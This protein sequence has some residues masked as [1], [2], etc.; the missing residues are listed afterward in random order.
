MIFAID[1]TTNKKIIVA[2]EA[3]IEHNIQKSPNAFLKDFF[4]QLNFNITI[5]Q[6]NLVSGHLNGVLFV[7]CQCDSQ[8]VSIIIAGGKNKKQTSK[9]YEF[10]PTDNNKVNILTTLTTDI[11]SMWS[12]LT[13][14]PT[15]TSNDIS[16]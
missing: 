15:K 14:K 12:S 1:P 4:E 11:R 7:M 13:I 9:Q 10:K 2:T 3:Y 5:C 6:Q 16:F 8:Y